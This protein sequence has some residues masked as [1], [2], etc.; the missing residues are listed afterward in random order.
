MLSNERDIPV[1][2]RSELWK[3]PTR[4]E[5]TNYEE[6]DEEGRGVEE[7]PGSNPASAK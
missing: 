1:D 2:V 7:P 6:R 5:Y 3:L 4:V